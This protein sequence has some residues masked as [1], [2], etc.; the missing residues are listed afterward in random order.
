[1]DWGPPRD[2]FPS[3]EDE[4]IFQT[5]SAVFKQKKENKNEIKREPS[6]SKRILLKL[7]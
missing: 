6:K 1:L 5:P 3:G 7:Y 2:L 4:D